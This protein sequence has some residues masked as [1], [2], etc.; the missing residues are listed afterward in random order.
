VHSN[1]EPVAWQQ[2]VLPER[3]AKEVNMMGTSKRAREE[4]IKRCSKK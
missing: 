4:E 1:E 3:E 2:G